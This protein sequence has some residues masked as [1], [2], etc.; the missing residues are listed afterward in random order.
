MKTAAL[1]ANRKS[2]IANRQF[3]ALRFAFAFTIL[4]AAHAADS[5]ASAR[6][7]LD[8]KKLPEAQQAFEQLAAADPKNAEVNYHLGDLALRR[9][10]LDQGVAYL[11][12]SVAADPQNSRYHHRLGDAYGTQAAEASVFR[13]LGFA[14]KCLAAYE[15]AVALDPKNVDARASLFE[16]Y[17]RAPSLL[18]GGFDKAAAQAAAIKQ[19]DA[20]RGRFLFA[21]LYAG[22]KKYAEAFAQY[23]EVL[24]ADP[25]DFA[26]L[27]QIGRLAATTGQFVDRGLTSLRRCLE[28]PAPTTPN[29][30][31]H[32]AAH[33]RLGNLLEKKHDPAGARAAY[34]AAVKLDPNFTPAAESLKK[35]K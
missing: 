11:E 25:N 18:G 15:R 22:E 28:L 33:W 24:Q 21:T 12:K 10:Q 27:F 35:L 2:P 16:F 3:L 30:P 14:K 31:G 29:T 1:P 4:T 32:A 6:A 7:L 9:H 34:E 5:I 20:P 23:D 8:A 26:A 13:Q 19:L 17:R